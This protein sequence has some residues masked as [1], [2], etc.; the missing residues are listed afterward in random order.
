MASKLLLSFSFFNLCFW[1][2]VWRYSGV[3][4]G[5]PLR[6]HSRSFFEYHMWHQEWNLG[7][8]CKAPS[9]IVCCL[10]WFSFLSTNVE[11]APT[12]CQKQKYGSDYDRMPFGEE[13]GQRRLPNSVCSQLLFQLWL[14][15]FRRLLLIQQHIQNRIFVTFWTRRTHFFMS[16]VQFIHIDERILVFK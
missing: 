12:M 14:M 10:C 5:F 15:T 8:Q 3:T 1:A 11:Q 7:Q 2:T 4:S 9:P 6:S 16:S 13:R